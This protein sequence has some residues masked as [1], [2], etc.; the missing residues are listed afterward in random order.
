[1]GDKPEQRGQRAACRWPTNATLGP[2]A[3]FFALPGPMRSSRGLLLLGQLAV[4]AACGSCLLDPAGSG[5]AKPSEAPGES[6]AGAR[7]GWLVAQEATVGGSGGAAGAL[8]PASQ[9]SR[10]A[11]QQGAEKTPLI[12]GA[13]QFRLP[14]FSAE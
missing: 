2:W 4:G 3:L 11:L 8:P 6:A 14:G 12:Q 13:L 7:D 10:R 5:A 1:M 9:A